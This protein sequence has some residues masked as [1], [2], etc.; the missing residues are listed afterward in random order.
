MIQFRK[1]KLAEKENQAHLNA[2][3]VVSSAVS[4]TI[5]S[6][7]HSAMGERNDAANQFGRNAYR[8]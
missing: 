6:S 5:S 3:K 1:S 2:R 4:E 8:K 7:P